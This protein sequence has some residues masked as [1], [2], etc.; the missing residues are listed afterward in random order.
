MF[1]S[2]GLVDAALQTNKRDID[3]DLVS[4]RYF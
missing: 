1:T 3:S 2:R 4:S